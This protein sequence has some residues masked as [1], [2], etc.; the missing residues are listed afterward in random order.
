MLI[1]NRNFCQKSKLLQQQIE[2]MINNRDFSQQ[3]IFVK[4]ANGS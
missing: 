4:H 3:L 2:T 1:K